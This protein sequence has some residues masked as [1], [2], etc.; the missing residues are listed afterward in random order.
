MLCLMYYQANS[1]DHYL[2]QWW[3]WMQ[4]SGRLATG[5]R[6]VPLAVRSFSALSQSVL[7]DEL[8]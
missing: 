5:A 4:L 6:P 1:S 8:D 7:V 3:P 2:A